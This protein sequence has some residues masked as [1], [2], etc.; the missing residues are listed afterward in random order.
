MEVLLLG[1]LEVRSSGERLP[2]G[3]PRQRALLAD[4]A[5]HAGSV[6]S[7]DTLLDDLWHGEPPATAEAVVQ[8][9][10][11]R[12]RRVAR[13]GRDRDPRARIRPSHRRRRH[14]RAALRA[15]RPGCGAPAAGRALGGARRRAGAL[16][17]DGV[18]RPRLRAVP[19]GRD[20][21]PRRGAADGARG[22]ARGRG[23]ARPSRRGDRRRD[24]APFPPHRPRARLSAHHAGAAPGGT[25]AGCAR[26]VRGHQARARRAVGPRALAR[27]A[28]PA[29]DD[30]DAGSRDRLQPARERG[31]WARCAGRSRSSSSSRCSTTT[32]S[33]S[34]REP[35]SRTCG[36]RPATSRPVTAA[37]SRPSRAWSSWWPS[38]STAP[39]RTT[40]SARR[41]RRSSCAR[42]SAAATSPPG[43]PSAR[44]ACSS[45]TPIPSW[46]ARCSAGRGVRCTTPRRTTS[47]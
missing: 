34:W 27:D 17:R 19:A 39:T 21:A 36:R 20:R 2:L 40:S 31:R 13:S 45:G 1:P 23:R 9:A 22:P 28:C 7:M 47:S 3:G 14:R 4:L 26:H 33:W 44:V 16:A 43:T 30:P 41:A 32:S 25:S 8:N 11:H 37:S 38:A 24:V 15:P 35:R 12:L 29:D 42:S 5:L 10:V 18:R 46:S 6:V